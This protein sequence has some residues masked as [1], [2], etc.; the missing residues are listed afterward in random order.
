MNTDRIGD[1]IDKLSIINI[2][3]WDATGKGHMAYE[4]GDDAKAH[5]LFLK[6]QTMN[7]QRKEYIN[8]IN[9]FFGEKENPLHDKTYA[10]KSPLSSK[11]KPRK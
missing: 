10:G 3:I 1:L 9:E 5:D 2:K 4:A 6:V 11:S 7:V 8:A